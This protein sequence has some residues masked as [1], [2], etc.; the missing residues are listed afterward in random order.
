MIGISLMLYATFLLLFSVMWQIFLPN[1][2][3]SELIVIISNQNWEIVS[4]TGFIGGIFGIFGIIGLLFLLLPQLSKIGFL[5]F[6]ILSVGLILHTCTLAWEAVL[7]KTIAQANPLT[8]LLT[9]TKTLYT[10]RN[11]IVFFTVLF[12]CFF[13]GWIL[14]GIELHRIKKLPEFLPFG[15]LFAGAFFQITPLIPGVYSIIGVY[16]ALLSTHIS[17]KIRWKLP[18]LG[19]RGQRQLRLPPWHEL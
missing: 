6:V 16:C 9:N 18:C 15:L 17:R 3:K 5:G 12:F 8:S 19:L 14:S 1:N 4:L 13:L 7:W 2:Q 11:S 10:G